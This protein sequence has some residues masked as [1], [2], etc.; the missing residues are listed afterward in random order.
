M[1]AVKLVGRIGNQLFIY[2]AAEAIRQK[3]GHNEKIVFYD[4]SVLR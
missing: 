2:A 4:E 1:I 3:R